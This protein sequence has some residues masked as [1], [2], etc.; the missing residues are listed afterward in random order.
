MGK[1]CVEADPSW[2]GVGVGL[3]WEDEQ[4]AETE[5]VDEWD[6]DNHL[7]KSINHNQKPY[8]W[9]RSDPGR[10]IPDHPHRSHRTP[11]YHAVHPTS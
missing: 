8:D 4:G 3:W 7:R 5:G 2:T 6:V 10:Y 1:V 11:P 9:R